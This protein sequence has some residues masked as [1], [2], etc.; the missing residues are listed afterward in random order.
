MGDF[1]RFVVPTLLSA[2]SALVFL[3][4]FTLVDL[5]IAWLSALIL[6]SLLG[7]LGARTT[8]HWGLVALSIVVGAVVGLS[9]TS[10]TFGDFDVIVTS[11]SVFFHVGLPA[12]GLPSLS[13]VPFL[14]VFPAVIISVW[15]SQRPNTSLTVLGP[16]VSLFL[17]ALFVEAVGV[18]WWVVLLFP[19]A[20]AA[21]FAF[22]SRSAVTTLPPLIGSSTEMRRHRSLVRPAVQLAST[23]AVVGGTMLVLGDRDVVDISEWVKPDI[24]IFEDPNPLAVAARWR[25]RDDLSEETFATVVVTGP[26]P[27]RLRLAVL[28]QYE[29]D[30]GWRQ[31]AEFSVTGANL[32]SDP[33]LP[34]SPGSEDVLTEVQVTID[35]ASPVFRAM[36]TGGRPRSVD[37]PRGVRFSARSG[38]LL[39]SDGESDI[40]YLS[41][42]APDRLPVIVEPTVR[43]LE[44]SCPTLAL[45]DYANQ[46]IRGATT[47]V[48]K[49]QAIRAFFLANTL[50]QRLFD[51]DAELGG[52][53]LNAVNRF[54]G[55]S[56]TFGGLEVYVT[57]FALLARCAGVPV[58]VVVGLP[59]PEDDAT[60]TFTKD[61]VTAWIEVP[62]EQSGWAPFDVIPTSEEQQA[63]TELL[64]STPRTDPP[65]TDNDPNV[66]DI[67]LVDPTVDEPGTSWIRPLALLGG[68]LTVLSLCWIYAV[69]G[70]I[71]RRRRRVATPSAAVDTAWLTVYEALADREVPLGAHLTPS[72]VISTAAGRTPFTVPRLL[73]H[74][75]P[76]VDAVH[77]SGEPATEQ[78]A[79]RAWSLTAI[80]L[81]QL[82]NVPLL[83]RAS[84]RHPARQFRRLLAAFKLGQGGVK[85]QADLPDDMV[86][87]RQD[88]PN[89]I[90]DVNVEAR[91]G[92]GSTGTVFRGTIVSSGQPVAV[93]V[94]RYGPG[95]PGF[96]LRRFEWEVRIAEQVSGLPNLPAVF[97]AGITPASGRPYI[98]ST[99]YEQGTLLDRVRRGGPMT[100]Q[101]AVRLGIDIGHA[102]ESLHRLGVVHADIKPENI[103]AGTEGWILGDLGSA[104]LRASQGPAA[105]ITPPY[106]APEVWRGA[107]P[108]P[109]SDIYSLGLTMLF[110]ATDRVPIAGNPPDQDQLG[111]EAFVDHQVVAQAL[112]SDPRRRPKRVSDFLHGLLPDDER[113][114]EESFGISLPTPTI[115]VSRV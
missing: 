106:A 114:L 98:V 36:P 102:L 67:E 14:V 11:F 93:K 97:G 8:V 20:C 75:A 28:T 2:L 27:G 63:Q 71:T 52:Q 68:L 41:A 73:A 29:I 65:Q 30:R 86:L 76:L 25:E 60:R 110:A 111:L 90:P 44:L 40:S 95:D 47:D 7:L 9:I 61:E 69:P 103:F 26:S 22:D 74:V 99:L 91:I 16:V 77:Y 3:N 43:S 109:L 64:R 108:T 24:E 15:A 50:E 18:P 13:V 59:A 94:F 58:R 101:E 42:V 56:P 53:T 113:E 32:A 51:N 49:L 45:V 19:L 31:A 89:D 10:R 48:D 21:V 1:R 66:E 72:E 23:L 70:I 38:V 85:W 87:A 78:D 12:V 107:N 4:A 115:T 100:P 81:E 112:E 55:P 35:S 105:R 17:G 62:L 79:G 80:V 57:S 82:P 34:R 88:A 37:E 96:D 5:T 46:V 92:E 33:N 6:G 39:R 83:R 54:L 84:V 104:W